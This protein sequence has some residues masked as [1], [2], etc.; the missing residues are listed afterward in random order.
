MR[1]KLY[2]ENKKYKG[3]FFGK[4]TDNPGV[5]IH[6]NTYTKDLTT[7]EFVT[8]SDIPVAERED[9]V[10]KE[11]WCF[12]KD[13]VVFDLVSEYKVFSSE[14]TSSGSNISITPFSGSYGEDLMTG[15][16]NGKYTYDKGTLKYWEMDM[17]LVPEKWEAVPFTKNDITFIHKEQ[18]Y[19]SK[20]GAI[21]IFPQIEEESG[22]AVG[23]YYDI[24]EEGNITEV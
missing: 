3:T 11:C 20:N 24:D 22:Q 12:V 8:L 4:V 9:Y 19:I 7:G 14:R 15:I 18:K 1:F 21:R 17:E 13:T 6:R 10:G 23:N 16:E 5:N 2:E